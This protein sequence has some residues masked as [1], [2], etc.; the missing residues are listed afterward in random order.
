MDS[1]DRHRGAEHG[2]LQGDR[3]FEVDVPALPDEEA[4]G[5]DLDANKGVAGV[6]LV[7]SGL[8]PCGATLGG[9]ALAFQPQGLAVLGPWFQGNVQGLAV[10]Q[11]D[12]LLR[13]QGRFD[14]VHLDGIGVVGAASYGARR[15][16]AE[17]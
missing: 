15:A 5:A 10:G 14:K 7:A 17:N 2:F 3:Q 13:A 1:R 8:A 6:R 16:L 9:L 12:P 11:P 4:V